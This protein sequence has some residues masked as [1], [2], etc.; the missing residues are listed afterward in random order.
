LE[1]SDELV[2]GFSVMIG[3]SRR[4]G[5]R[6]RV[7]RRERIDRID[8]RGWTGGWWVVVEQLSFLS[9]TTALQARIGRS[10]DLFRAIVFSELTDDDAIVQPTP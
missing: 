1:S 4:G 9:G 2:V 5:V 3:I 8:R 6:L 10:V 7:V